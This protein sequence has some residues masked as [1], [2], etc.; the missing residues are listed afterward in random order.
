MTPEPLLD[1]RSD[2]GRAPSPK[3]RLKK[4]S[5][6]SGLPLF[7][8]RDALI[9]TT[10]GIARFAAKWYEFGELCLLL[11]ASIKVADEV[12]LRFLLIPKP[13]CIQF[14]FKLVT[15]NQRAKPTVTVCANNC[16]SLRIMRSLS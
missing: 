12:K 1:G 6:S 3:K 13:C 16:Q 15:I 8:L 9:L 10:E 14:G 2:L 11:G 7:E 5:L 4:G